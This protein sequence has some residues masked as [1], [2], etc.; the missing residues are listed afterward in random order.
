VSWSNTIFY[1]PVCYSNYFDG[2]HLS[3]RRT[4]QTHKPLYHAQGKWPWANTL[5]IA[6]QALGG[7]EIPTM[8]TKS[9][10][11][12]WIKLLGLFRNRPDRL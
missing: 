12:N 11:E 6:Q 8:L 9:I 1:A 2:R 10:E 3:R 7:G 5:T 4:K